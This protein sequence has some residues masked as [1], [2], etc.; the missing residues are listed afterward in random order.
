MMQGEPPEAFAALTK[1]RIANEPIAYI[2]GSQDFY[3]REFIVTPDVLIPRADSESVV[4]AALSANPSP[5]RVLDCGTGSGALLLTLIA[6]CPDAL[7]VGIDSSA[8]ALEVAARNAAAL[9]LA[10]RAQMM[11]KNWTTP[12]W[13][14]DLGQFDLI[15]ANPPYVEE[16]AE[17][18]ADVR[19]HEPSQ[20]LFSGPEGLDDYRILIPQLPQLLTD[21]GVAVLEIGYVQAAAVTKIAA[22]QG[23][24]AQVRQDLAGR[25]R[26]VILRLKLGKAESTG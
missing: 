18:A 15:I 26:A 5:K 19:D 14:D 25:D 12:S 7:G 24:A 21:T 8:A 6:E 4:E 1:R 20:A 13:A 10:G 11:E 23:F 16:N 22:E 9:D 17:L 2:L 3:G